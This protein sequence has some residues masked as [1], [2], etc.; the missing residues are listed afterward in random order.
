MKT[1]KRGFNFHSPFYMVLN[2]DIMK[3][4]PRYNFWNFKKPQHPTSVSSANIFQLD[5][6]EK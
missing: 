5:A 6:K 4:C 2:K 3:T 1:E